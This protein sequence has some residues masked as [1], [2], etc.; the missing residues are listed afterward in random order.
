MLV[1][2]IRVTM[3]NYGWQTAH[4]TIPQRDGIYGNSYHRDN[5]W[6]P[7]DNPMIR[8]IISKTFSRYFHNKIML[9]VHWF[10]FLQNPPQQD[11]LHGKSRYHLKTWLTRGIPMAHI[12][13]PKTISKYVLVK[14]HALNPLFRIF[15]KPTLPDIPCNFTPSGHTMTDP[16]EP[17][18][19][20]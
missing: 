11:A 4:S 9:K 5:I 12:I 18:H 1:Q 7:R 16:L 15:C 2:A 19:Y 8:I 3:S 10:V 20:P 14:N 6:L 17:H 13:I